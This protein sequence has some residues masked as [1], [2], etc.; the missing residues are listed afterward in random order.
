MNIQY[1][2]LTEMWQDAQY[3]EV[4]ELSLDIALKFI[5]KLCDFDLLIL[6]LFF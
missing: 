1:L 3:N 6:G 2:K 4:G 5:Q